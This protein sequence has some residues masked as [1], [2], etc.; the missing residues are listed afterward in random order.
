MN[1]FCTQDFLDKNIRV[2]PMSGVS[3][4]ED[5]RQ[6]EQAKNN[7]PYG[8][9][10]DKNE[11]DHQLEELEMDEARQEIKRVTGIYVA[12]KKIEDEKA[13]KKR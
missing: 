4:S 10:I 8:E 13:K 12:K 9:K 6:N 2:R 3:R 5:Q 1:D 7:D 11:K